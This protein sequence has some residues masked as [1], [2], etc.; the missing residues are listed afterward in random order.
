MRSTPTEVACAS[1]TLAPAPEQRPVVLFAEPSGFSPRVLELLANDVDVRL[2]TKGTRNALLAAVGEADVL[3]VRL[4][5]RVDAEL[6]AAAPR[7]R[8]IVTPTTGLNHVDLEA[9]RERGIAVLTLRGQTDFL[10][11]VR[12]T[13]EHTILLMLALLRHFPEAVRHVNDGG[14][15]RDLFRGRELHGATVGLVG[16]GRLGRLVARTLLA[17]G[18][19]VL[20]SDPHVPPAAAPEGVALVPLHELLRR[21]DIVSLHASLGD[22]SRG[23]FGFPEIGAM[24][25]GALLVNTARG[26]LVDEYA[27]LAALEG[28]RLGGAALDVL[29]D[30]DP[31]GMAHHP[32]VAYARE[33][34][35]LIV[36]PHVGGCTLESMEKTEVFMAETLVAHLGEEAR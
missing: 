5:Y 30:E 16:F 13:A 23:F 19:R 3:W 31:R 24:R 18:S 2:L 6:L 1:G 33:H 25:R 29:A 12:A 10:R 21:A 27:V 28:G 11:D 26:E 8:A 34:P 14:W 22:E 35:N 7:L 15:N 17:F 32:L 36:T 4:G 20:A 9:A